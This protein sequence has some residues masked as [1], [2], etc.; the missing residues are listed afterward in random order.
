[1][2]VLV[3][4]AAFFFSL[5]PFCFHFQR[6]MCVQV[7]GVIWGAKAKGDLKA[8]AMQSGRG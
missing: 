1:M 2:L 4:P 6:L 5:P 7:G 8:T 3:V